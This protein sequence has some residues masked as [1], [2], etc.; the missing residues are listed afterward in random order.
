MKQFEEMEVWQSARKMAERIYAISEIPPFSRDYGLRDQIRRASISIISN[1]AEGFESQSNLNFCRFQSCAKASA[2]EI[3]AQLYLTS[4]LGYLSKNEFNSLV[5]Q[6]E[7][8]SRQISGFISY[9]KSN[10]KK[11]RLSQSRHP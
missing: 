4:N 7:S 2:G 3:R 9:L 1:I 5:F 10:P 8:I 11:P 6:S